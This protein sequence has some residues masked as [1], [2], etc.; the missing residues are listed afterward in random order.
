M[1]RIAVIVVLVVC[2][3]LLGVS[4]PMD[5]S[6]GLWRVE[7]DVPTPSVTTYVILFMYH[8]RDALVLYIVVRRV[9]IMTGKSIELRVAERL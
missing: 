8:A 5:L 7:R 4:V 6:N 1:N 3:A 9:N 2:F